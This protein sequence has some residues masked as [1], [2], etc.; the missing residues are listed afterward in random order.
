MNNKKFLLILVIL[1]SGCATPRYKGS[2]SFNELL[3][4]R[5][6]CLHPNASTVNIEINIASSASISCAELH[7][8]LAL[9]GFVR[10]DAN[11]NHEIPAQYQITCK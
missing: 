2:G 8:C 6:E 3:K 10:D 7:T 4:A 5:Y 11:G 9:K 1:I